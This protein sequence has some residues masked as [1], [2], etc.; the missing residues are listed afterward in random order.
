M[1]AMIRSGWSDRWGCDRSETD[2]LFDGLV[3]RL[4]NGLAA[5][6]AI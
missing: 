2:V 4:E 3:A 6:C 5:Y 1:G